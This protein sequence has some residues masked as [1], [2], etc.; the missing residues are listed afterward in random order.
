MESGAILTLAGI[1]RS[2]GEAGD[3]V[4][5]TSSMMYRAIKE[6]LSGD[7]GGEAVILCLKTGK[8]YGLNVLGARIWELLQSPMSLS[9]IEEIIL[10]EF[11]VEPKECR[12]EV[13]SFIGLLESEGLI[14]RVDGVDSEVPPTAKDGKGTNS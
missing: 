9:E 10:S 13:N 4:D 5:V 7:L 11:E 1:S 8:Y 14:E 2:S 12:V 3:R 6:Q